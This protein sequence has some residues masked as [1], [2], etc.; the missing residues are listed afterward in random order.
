M[1][2][3]RPETTRPPCPADAGGAVADA[4]GAGRTRCITP[5]ST[6]VNHNMLCDVQ[7]HGTSHDAARWSLQALFHGSFQAAPGGWV[8]RAPIPR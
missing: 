7:H 3:A 6:G 8:T 5:R 2:T 4:L 1:N